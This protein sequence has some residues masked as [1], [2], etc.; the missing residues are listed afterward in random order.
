[1]IKKINIPVMII[2]GEL[3]TVVSNLA[4]KSVFEALPDNDEVKKKELVVFD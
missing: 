4:A 3:D 2:L 1:M